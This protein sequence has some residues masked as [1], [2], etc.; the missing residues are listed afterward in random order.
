MADDEEK[1]NMTLRAIAAENAS[2]QSA[3]A[4]IA[5]RLARL[6]GLMQEITSDLGQAGAALAADSLV[7][8]EAATLA[9]D[10]ARKSGSADAVLVAERAQQLALA[11]QDSAMNVRAYLACFRNEMARANQADAR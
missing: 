1:L 6:Q 3:H 7:A 11:I 2:I 9:L 5:K 10:L 4:T 8:A